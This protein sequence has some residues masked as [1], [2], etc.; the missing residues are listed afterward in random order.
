MKGVASAPGPGGGRGQNVKEEHGS[1]R[2][3]HV[4]QDVLETRFK[5]KADE[6][7][8]DGQKGEFAVETSMPRERIVS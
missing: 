3:T 8:E 6:V 4:C 2:G 7:A 5:K 1:C